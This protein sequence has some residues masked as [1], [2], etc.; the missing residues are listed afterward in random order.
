MNPSD[1]GMGADHPVDTSWTGRSG[2]VGLSKA[3]AGLETTV[4]PP[5]ER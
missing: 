2:G 4:L 5:A 3:K 1:R